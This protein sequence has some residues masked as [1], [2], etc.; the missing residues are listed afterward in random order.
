MQE[1][2]DFKFSNSLLYRLNTYQVVVVIHI[3]NRHWFGRRIDDGSP[4]VRIRLGHLVDSPPFRLRIEPKHLPAVEH[5][6]PDIPI[7]IGIGFVEIGIRMRCNRRPEFLNPLR[8]R[9]QLDEGAVRSSPPRIS[10]RIK[11]PA[12]GRHHVGAAV[13]IQYFPRLNLQ[14]LDG[15]APISRSTASPIFSVVGDSIVVTARRLQ[16]P[17]LQGLAGYRI[18]FGDPVRARIPYEAF[19]IEREISEARRIQSN[20]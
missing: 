20:M 12:L 2:S 10:E 15:I 13:Q 18:E 6:G 14:H 17:L 9:V 7:F 16:R 3:P 4:I 8:L 19:F 11:T 5:T 1:S